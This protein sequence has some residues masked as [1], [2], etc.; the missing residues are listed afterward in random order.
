MTVTISSVEGNIVHGSFSGTGKT[1]DAIQNG[2]FTCRISNYHAQQDADTRWSFGAWIDPSFG[3]YSPYAGNVTSAALSE[4]NGIHYLTVNGE[5][6]HG[7]SVFKLVISNST[8]TIHRG[9]YQLSESYEEN[10]DS[11]LFQICSCRLG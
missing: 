11:F 2:T 4:A 3:D 1:G 5:S 10:V 9:W 7:A 6:D 8:D